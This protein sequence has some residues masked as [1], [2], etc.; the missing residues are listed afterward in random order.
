MIYILVFTLSLLCFKWAQYFNK[1][2][3]KKFFYFFSVLGIIIPCLLAAVRDLSMGTDTDTYVKRIFEQAI[4][5]NNLFTFVQHPNSAVK[6]FLYLF[7]SFICARFTKNISVLLFVNELLVI[8]PLYIALVKSNKKSGSIVFGMFIFF[9]FFYNQSFNL[10]RQSI[11]ISF[12]I[13]AIH[14]LNE[15]KDLKFIFLSI[16]ACLY[17]STAL[18]LLLIYVLYKIEDKFK[19]YPIKISYFNR[20]LS[21]LMVGIII[22]FPS[23]VSILIKIGIAPGKL[24]HFLNSYSLGLNI[25]WTNTLFYLFIA[26]IINVNKLKNK[27]SNFKFYKFG[28]ILCLLI[29]QFGARIKFAERIGY[30]LFYPI[31]FLTL[32]KLVV[33]EENTITKNSLINTILISIVF[34]I[35]WFFWII[36]QR[37]HETYPFVFYGG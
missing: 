11:A 25:N 19:K 5:D 15:K 27:I 23:F 10:T 33:D 29:L 20:I 28:S 26:L 16:I 21:I 30:Y 8:L 12:S 18:I 37:Y 14:Y 36:I 9:M 24:T 31:I 3:N 34:I 1:N 7:T 13:L 2:Q 6:D 22:F 4:V 17:H 32:P 35:Y